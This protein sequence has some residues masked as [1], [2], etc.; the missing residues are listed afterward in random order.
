LVS[1]VGYSGEQH[2]P[3]AP[4]PSQAIKPFL[5][6]DVFQLRKQCAEVRSVFVCAS[7]LSFLL[8]LFSTFPRYKLNTLQCTAV[9][10]RAKPF[11]VKL[12]R[13]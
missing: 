4:E 3:W 10:R 11:T 13:L 9:E 6:S 8:V 2:W 7:L 12:G 5:D 1:I